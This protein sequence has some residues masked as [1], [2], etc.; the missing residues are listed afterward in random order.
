MRWFKTKFGAAVTTATQGTPFTL[1][2][3]TAIAVQ[4]SF[5]VWGNIFDTHPIDQVLELC[6]GDVIDGPRRTAFP[7]S[8]AALL[9]MPKGAQIFAVARA[10][11]E[12]VGMVNAAYHK[13]AV[14]NPETNSVMGSE[15]FRTISSSARRT[16]ITL[17][18]GAG[19]HSMPLW[20][21]P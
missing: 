5:E 16:Q 2:F 18:G 6:V 11:L 9:A 14:S 7:T 19:R 17:S 13:I 21:R 12:A 20:G 15:F 10:E 1:D 4:E 3:L 8:K